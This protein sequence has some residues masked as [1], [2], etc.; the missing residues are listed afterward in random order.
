MDEEDQK[1]LLKPDDK[2]F[3]PNRSVIGV[4]IESSNARVFFTLNGREIAT[5]TLTGL[6]KDAILYPTFSLSTLEDK[7]HVNFGQTQFMYNLKSKLNVSPF[8]NNSAQEYYNKVFAE[9]CNQPQI[10]S[11]KA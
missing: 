8:F 5:T 1:C 3:F 10:A 11:L 2:Q 4:G 6:T 9:I 7:I